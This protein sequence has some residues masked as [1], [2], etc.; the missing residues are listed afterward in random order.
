MTSALASAGPSTYW[1]LT[2]STG[3]VALVLLTMS[4]VLGV[5][6]VNRWNS[7][8]WPR[9]VVDGV[10][11][12]ASLLVVVFICLHVLTALLDSFA[13]IA[14]SDA[15]LPF[16]GIYRPFWLGLGAL[17]FDVLLAIVVTSL[18]RQRIGHRAWRLTHWLAYASWPL[19]LVHGL[20]T[21]SDIRS[22]WMLGLSA[23]CL[24]AVMYAIGM[25]VSS[26]WPA[27]PAVR[28]SAI[29]TAACVPIALLAWLPGGPMASD[30]ARRSGTPSALLARASSRRPVV[31]ST[32]P[33]QVAPPGA[34]GIPFRAT[35]AGTVTQNPLPNPR[36][37]AVQIS[38]GFS[39][40]VSGHLSIEIDGAPLEGGGVA[41]RSSHVTLTPAPPALSYEGV[42][43]AL[44][45]NRIVARVRRSGAGR[46][47]LQVVLKISQAS[48]R[49]T[50]TLESSPA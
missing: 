44:Q 2:R 34:L 17:A 29:A 42:I 18:L 9:F 12:T 40:K 10:H 3:A 45:E 25:R 24:L 31:H 26:G 28:G 49:V 46:L 1:Y 32:S 23:A 27:R 38:T 39:G 19:A 7:P 37:V 6:D 20:G 48:S 16:L 47:T 11:R 8:R 15:V 50:G 14:V 36:L 5:L 30:W 43:V 35:L 13:P 41:L 21:G 33:T 22:G 4:V